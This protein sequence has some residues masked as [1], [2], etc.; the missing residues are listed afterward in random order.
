M[1]RLTPGASS[2]TTSSSMQN[3]AAVRAS[4]PAT[5]VASSIVCV[6]SIT[7]PGTASETVHDL[8]RSVPSLACSDRLAAFL[9]TK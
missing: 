6:F 4:R 5:A 2:I 7:E 1:A 3:T 9:R 8:P